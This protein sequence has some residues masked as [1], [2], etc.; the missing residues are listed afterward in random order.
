MAVLVQW[1]VDFLLL[2]RNDLSPKQ[3][4]GSINHPCYR[5]SWQFILSYKNC[6]CWL[7]LW[8]PTPTRHRQARDRCVWHIKKNFEFKTN[9]LTKFVTAYCW[10]CMQTWGKSIG[11]N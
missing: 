8:L 9:G 2:A 4:A 1:S 6:N 7:H 11:G 10:S 3:L 5:I